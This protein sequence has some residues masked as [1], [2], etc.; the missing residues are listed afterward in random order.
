MEEIRIKSIQTRAWNYK[1]AT[2]DYKSITNN[3]HQI[4]TAADY[5]NFKKG[6]AM[7]PQ[8]TKNKQK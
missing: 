8:N 6:V 2:K 1:N 7:L 3:K 4:A 5:V